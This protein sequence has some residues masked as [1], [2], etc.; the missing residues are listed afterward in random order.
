MA[1]VGLMPAAVSVVGAC[2][3]RGDLGSGLIPPPPQQVQVMTAVP[4]P[5]LRIS[6]VT[7]LHCWFYQHST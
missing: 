7:D 1:G 6:M 5:D 4:V 3:L 2:T